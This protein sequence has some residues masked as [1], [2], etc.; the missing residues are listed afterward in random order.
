MIWIV[1]IEIFEARNQFFGDIKRE[2]PQDEV[3]D[4]EKPFNDNSFIEM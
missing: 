3:K 1:I 4:E 2:K